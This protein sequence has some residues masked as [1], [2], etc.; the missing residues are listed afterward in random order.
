MHRLLATSF[1]LIIFF[2][3]C[4]RNVTQIVTY[5][6]QMT[7]TVSFRGAIDLTN[8]R[9]F[10]VISSQ[11]SYSLPL[12]PPEGSSTD[13][14]LEPG[15][16]PISGSISDYYSKYYSSWHSLVVADNLGI[17]IIPGP[18]STT[19]S[20]TREIISTIPAISD[21]I[22]FTIRLDKIFTSSVPE[23]IYFDII[24]ANYP[25]SSQKYLKDHIAPPGRSISKVT[26]SILSQ[27]DESKS[28]IDASQDITTW[29]VKIE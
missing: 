21:N 16:S 11:E 28:D 7:V 4:A 9:Y 5:G 29:T 24:S 1:A 18:F 13:E 15:D 10:V 27:S 17:F 14:F 8:N 23:T 26:G 19:S 20:T 25:P 3:G 22:S 2:S 12:L 6:T